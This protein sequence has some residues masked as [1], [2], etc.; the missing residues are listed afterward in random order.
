MM[1]KYKNEGSY[2]PYE[3]DG[4]LLSFRGGELTINL[5]E[6]QCGY[7]LRVDVSEDAEGRLVTG[8]AY[9]YVAEIDI[10]RR[11]YRLNYK[12]HTDDLGIAQTFRTVEPF[13]PSEAALTLWARRV[14]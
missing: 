4:V 7:P 14:R 9:R 6:R 11:V 13:D 12:G 5:E 3:L 8:S 2:I 10:P 1:V